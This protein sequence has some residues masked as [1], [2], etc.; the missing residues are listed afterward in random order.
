MEVISVYRTAQGSSR[1]LAENLEELITPGV[2]TIVCGDFNIC[3]MSHRNNKVTHFLETNGFHQMMQE[4]THIKG[5]HIDHFYF[6]AGMNVREN[7]SI[8]RYSPY[9]SDHDANCVTI[10]LHKDSSPD[11]T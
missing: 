1:Q 6:K 10:R 11:K 7:P 4:A 8:F 2:T 3:Y 5:G 9:Y